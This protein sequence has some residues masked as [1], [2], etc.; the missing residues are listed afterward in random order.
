MTRLLLVAVIL[1]LAVTVTAVPA[2]AQPVGT[3]RWQLQPY[4]NVVTMTVTQQGANYQLD[5]YDDQC[6]GAQRAPLVGMGTPNPDGS[7][8]L[9]LN[10]VTSPAGRGLQV[11][12]RLTLPSAS[13]TWSDSAGNSGMFAFGASTGG[14]PRPAPTVPGSVVPNAFSLLADGGFLARGTGQTGVIPAS[15]AGTR[16]MWHPG[17]A[18]LR[19]G[20]VTT[21]AWDDARVGLH[22]TA[23][24]FD[25]EASGA[26][27]FAAGSSSAARGNSSTAFG[28]QAQAIGIF[29]I[30][31]G[32]QAR[33]IGIHSVA[34]GAEPTASGPFSVAIGNGATASGF[35]STAIGNGT[36]ASGENSTAMGAT[37]TAGGNYSTAMG[38]GTMA[39]GIFSTAMGYNTTASG[40]NSAAMGWRTRAE[41]VNT[42]VMG[43][44]ATATAAAPGSFV[45]GDRSTANAGQG[46]VT[47]ISPNQFLVRAAGGVVF[48]STPSSRIDVISQ[49]DSPGVRLFSG[50]SGW[51]PLSDVRSKENFRDLTHED[52]LGRIAQMPVREWNYIA[53]GAGIR[54]MGPTAQDFHAAFGLGESDLRINTIDADGV[55]LAGV[56]ALEART[57]SLPG[58]TLALREQMAALTRENDDLRARLARLESLLVKR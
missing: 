35:V 50:A 45:Y 29:S 51:S 12:A 14:S 42:T 37:T 8:G 44:Y 43:S 52:V 17:K 30:A 24:G 48:W 41:G 47:S 22:S 1:A 5:G 55:A 15:G 26:Y 32:H 46:V 19:A 16:M 36:T 6:G 4:C 27:S 21:T 9:G 38:N 23:F 34:F 54:H 39:T 56:R 13:G 7:V 3:F 40:E 57:R 2:Q 10:L 20:Q 33:A 53:Q 49:P 11:A 25:A 58:D 28:D 31:G 18:A